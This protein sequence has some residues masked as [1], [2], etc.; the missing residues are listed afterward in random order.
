MDIESRPLLGKSDSKCFV[1]FLTCM[2]AM[3]GLLFGYDTGIVSGSMLLIKDDFKLSSVWQE[4]IVS[5]TIGAAAVFA[6]ISG[7]LVDVLGRKTVIMASSFIFTAGAVVM[8]LSPVDL[9]EVLLVGRLIVGA[10]IGFASMSVPVYIA[11]AAPTNIRGS[12]VTMNQL[13]ITIGILLSSIVAG[14]FSTNKDNGWRYMLGLAGVPSV[15]QFF[16]FFFLPESPRWLISKGRHTQ[17]RSALERIRGTQDVA[18]ELNLIQQ[19]VNEMS[20]ENK[21]NAFQAFVL[22]MKTQPVRRA[23]V[24]GC[25]LQ[26][27]GQ[28][29][30]I[31]TVIYYSGTILRMSGFPSDLAI[32]LVCIPFAVN[33]LFTFIGVYAVERAGRRILT[34]SSFIGI[35]IALVVLGLGFWLSDEHSPSIHHHLDNSSI[36]HTKYQTCGTCIK[37]DNCG[38]CWEKKDPDTSGYCLHVYKTHPERYAEP[39]VNTTSY[40]E[41]L[42]NKTYDTK[43][44]GWAND[45]CPTDY[46]WMAVLG[47]AL[48]VMSFAPGLGPNPWTINSEIYPLW[49]RG[50]GISIATAVNWAANLGVSFSFLTLLETI[51]TY[52]TFFL[53]AGTSFVGFVTL[54]FLLPETKNRS[55]EEIEQLFMTEAYR[56]RR[57]SQRQYNVQSAAYRSDIH[58]DSPPIM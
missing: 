6:L 4:A 57:E 31:N 23:L 20:E 37:D 5:A 29:S 26:L 14:A 41:S 38:F 46:S 21:Y 52:G 47:L 55:L 43:N 40:N 51:T 17:A 1:I 54:Y 36:C 50:T 25:L 44:Y 45:F 32:W 8:A 56:A 30:G 24:L 12:L 27:F 33:F 48:F 22:M 42:C 16:G 7:T 10:A 49:A 3:G 35:I 53:Y 34:L 2:A 58:D 9:K 39:E 28:F 19:S 13:F 15:I 18:D 11:E